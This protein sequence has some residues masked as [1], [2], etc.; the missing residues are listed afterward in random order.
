[1]R[2]F[3]VLFQ[4]DVGYHSDGQ[5][6]GKSLCCEKCASF[7]RCINKAGSSKGETSHYTDQLVRLQTEKSLSAMLN[8]LCALETTVERRTL[9]CYGHYNCLGIKCHG[10]LQTRSIILTLVL[11]NVEFDSELHIY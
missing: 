7:K 1:M 9:L 8:D 5:T 3:Y 2:L 4:L 6:G 11:K 10:L